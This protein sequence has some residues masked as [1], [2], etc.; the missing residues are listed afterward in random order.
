MDHLTVDF[1]AL[2]ASWVDE[3]LIAEL[4][5]QHL[6][7]FI[8]TLNKDRS[9]QE[10]IEKN[11]SGVITDHPDIALEIRAKQSEQQYFLQRVL[12]RLSFIF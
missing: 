10:F 12:N 9:L 11:V 8:W 2:E 3:S 4:N 6:D 1:I 7:L 5:A